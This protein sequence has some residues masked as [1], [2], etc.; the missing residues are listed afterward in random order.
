MWLGGGFFV[1]CFWEKGLDCGEL[2]RTRE[3]D[4]QRLFLISLVTLL[5]AAPVFAAEPPPIVVTIQSY[6]DLEADF[7]SIAKRLKP[8]S[9]DEAWEEF[10]RELK[11]ADLKGI[12]LTRPWQA[13]TW[14]EIAEK[15]PSMSFR[16]PILDFEGFR[17]S[18]EAIAE[19]SGNEDISIQ[20]IGGYANVW[21]EGEDSPAAAKE[22]H[23]A[24]TPALLRA[25]KKT[26]EVAVHF[27]EAIRRSILQTIG[28]GKMAIT[29]GLGSVPDGGIPGMNP[30]ALVELIGVYFEVAEMGIQGVKTLELH[31]GVEQELLEIG[32][33]VTAKADSELASWLKPTD[34]SLE[35]VLPFLHS[36]AA[37]AFAMQFVD[38]P[39]MMPTVKKFSRLSF[40][41]QGTK[42]DDP[43]I[44]GLE[45]LLDATIPM[46]F[47]NSSDFADGMQFGG[48][49]R[50]PGRDLD[51]I[52]QMIVRYVNGPL[53]S[54]V[55]PKKMYKTLSLKK[56][57]R[58]VD[59]VSVDRFFMEI[60]WDAPMYQ[61][62]NVSAQERERLAEMWPFGK[63]E[64]DMAQKGG[65]LFVGSP[66]VFDD[67]LRRD[68]TDSPPSGIPFSPRTFAIDSRTVN[69][70][71]KHCSAIFSTKTT[72][73]HQFP[74]HIGANLHLQGG[75]NNYLTDRRHVQSQFFNLGVVTCT[76]L[77]SLNDGARMPAYISPF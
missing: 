66:Q 36:E 45:K 18:M 59:G 64:F 29:G 19:S 38:N 15:T 51:A 17:T 61:L 50:F 25:P 47:A 2:G 31:L 6:Q 68:S 46:V 13:A 54:Q 40:E 4:M 52:Y 39:A 34:G 44:R 73:F 69:V 55:G 24:W 70:T 20:Q 30:R 10:R 56:A 43:A 49:Y 67:L 23:D 11:I 27:P 63:V 37:M 42:K 9:A 77:Q 1:A 58:E 26:I 41:M 21:I 35:S 33:K 8:D 60:N 57:H 16:I 7:K 12:D 71:A 75:L 74:L 72:I 76:Y 5:S 32:K 28:M 14:W 65:N 3:K 22:R 48:V 62:Q 53:Q